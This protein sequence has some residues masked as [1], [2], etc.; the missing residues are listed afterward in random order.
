M[1]PITL[2]KKNIE[3]TRSALTHTS[4]PNKLCE[5]KLAIIADSLAKP[6]L[7]KL[8]ATVLS[9]ALLPIAP[10]T[11]ANIISFGDIKVKVLMI[12][13]TKQGDSN[14]I[15]EVID[16]LSDCGIKTILGVGVAKSLTNQIPI[17][18]IVLAEAAIEAAMS[19]CKFSYPHHGLFNDLRVCAASACVSLRRAKVVCVE[20]DDPDSAAKINGSRTVGAEV[21]STQTA[22]LYS[23][24]RIKSLASA[25]ISIVGN[26][27]DMNDNN[28]V[29]ALLMRQGIEDLA[30]LISKTATTIPNEG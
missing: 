4:K 13:C 17:G 29:D 15:S 27:A 11:I 24:S 2:N 6:I 7:Q 28:S 16:Y 3:I 22:K 8:R 12:E 5:C 1:S 14:N 25:H 30:R 18:Q 23:A 19:S 26:E 10:D 21:I 20:A 9:E